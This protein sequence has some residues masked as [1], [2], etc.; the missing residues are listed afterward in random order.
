MEDK[1][2]YLVVTRGGGMDGR[3]WMDKGGKI[4]YAS[5][6]KEDSSK[7]LDPWNE[8]KSVIDDGTFLKDANKKINPLDRLV[9]GL[10]PKIRR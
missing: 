8:L 10:D 1:I 2:I 3:D 6:D 7:H 5:L 4:T 9:L